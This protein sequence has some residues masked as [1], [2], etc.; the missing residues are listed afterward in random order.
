MTNWLSMRLIKLMESFYKTIKK[1]LYRMLIMRLRNKLEMIFLITLNYI[2]EKTSKIL[3]HYAENP[4]E[5]FEQA[6]YYFPHM[7]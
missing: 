1:S 4:A 6:K 7:F 2:L 3:H 5:V